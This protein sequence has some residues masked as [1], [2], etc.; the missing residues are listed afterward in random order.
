MVYLVYKN[1]SRRRLNIMTP[2]SIK[3]LTISRPKNI[4]VVTNNM[5]SIDFTRSFI[6][7]NFPG[8]SIITENNIPYS[9]TTD[10]F[11]LTDPEF[12]GSY[13]RAFSD[14]I[15]PKVMG[16]TFIVMALVFAIIVLS[17]PERKTYHEQM[18]FIMFLQCVG[19]LRMRGYPM[20]A[21]V[22]AT[23]IGFAQMELLF[24]PNVFFKLF[25][26]SYIE[27]AY[28][29]VKF[30]WGYHN[31]VQHMG[32]VFL[33]FLILQVLL[34]VYYAA[35]G[36]DTEHF[37]RYKLLQE[38]L[39]EFFMPI[40]IF[41]VTQSFISLTKNSI[42]A[43]TEF[44]I[45]QLIATVLL[46]L[47]LTYLIG[48]VRKH[49]IYEMYKVNNFIRAILLGVMCVNT[50]GG[51]IPLIVIEAILIIVDAKLYREIKI[52][53]RLYA[54]DRV[55]MVIALICGCIINEFIPLLALLGVSVGIIFLIKG[56]YIV[57][58]FIDWIAERKRRQLSDISVS[59]IVHESVKDAKDKY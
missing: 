9:S 59:D 17:I 52:D 33:I 3:S 23:L 56:Y 35:K 16:I 57:R 11:D 30:A 26:V 21:Y 44:M 4:I 49:M 29:S 38:F 47:Y 48:W 7:I 2:L 40:T 25:P 51:L 28:D 45:S 1:G 15:I 54:I 31:F 37:S 58:R 43:N 8:G 46:F 27:E 13:Y 41:N 55:A 36:K 19:F 42:L 14:S 5:E 32:S 12:S 10:T 39:I 18:T 53:K 24:I 20:L 6:Q 34:F 22:Y 50:Y